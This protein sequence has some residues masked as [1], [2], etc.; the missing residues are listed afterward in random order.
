MFQGSSFHNG[1]NRDGPVPPLKLKWKFQTQGRIMTSPVVVDRVVYFGSRDG[2]IYALKLENGVLKWKYNIGFGGINHSIAIDKTNNLLYTGSWTPLTS[3]GGHTKV[4]YHLYEFAL[5]KSEII[6][7]YKT[8]EIEN[9]PPC[10]TV[11]NSTVYVN[12]DTILDDPKD[13]GK[14]KKQFYILAIDS[15]SKNIKWKANLKGYTISP[16]T[17]DDKRIYVG[18]TDEN[19]VQ[20]FDVETGKLIWEYKTDGGIKSSPSLEGNYLY[21]ASEDKYLYCLMSDS[22]K[23]NWKYLIGDKMVSTPAVLNGNKHIFVST[24]NGRLQGFDGIN[25]EPT[26]KFKI[27]KGFVSS[28]VI[29]P[30]YVYITGMDGYIYV[31][32]INKGNLIWRYKVG[33]EITTSPA[34]AYEILF[35]SSDDG[36][37]YAFENINKENT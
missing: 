9:V 8:G 2:N 34:I 32:D 11:R 37:L 25:L 16:V 13:K 36:C 15:L 6:G 27:F 26:W 1:V 5:S 14:F 22:G 35:V 10:V 30:K 29:N 21:I 31:L 28:P 3:I 23:L 4:G 20:A 18:T 33:D 19:F 17:V 24:Y 12:S 7:K